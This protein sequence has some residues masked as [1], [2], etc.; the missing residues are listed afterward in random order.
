MIKL[1]NDRHTPITVCTPLF[2]K[3]E[4]FGDLNEVMVDLADFN[5]PY[6]IINYDLSHAFFS[7]TF[8]LWIEIDSFLNPLIGDFLEKCSIVFVKH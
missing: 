4:L 5:T 1:C 7:D 6:H 8:L 2:A 3:K